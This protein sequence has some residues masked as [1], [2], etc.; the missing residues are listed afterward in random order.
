M[1]KVTVKGV[2]HKL[3]GTSIAT[4]EVLTF[5]AKD[6]NNNDFFLGDISGGKVISVF[7]A[8]NTR[9]CDAQTLKIA[10]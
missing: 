5:K 1:N 10:Q 3:N 2:E 7:P 6:Q 4:N 9:V 8:L